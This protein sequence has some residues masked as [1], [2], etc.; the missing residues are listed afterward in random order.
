M[1]TLYTS[2]HISRKLFAH[3]TSQLLERRWLLIDIEPLLSVALYQPCL[4]MAVIETVKEAFGLGHSG[5]I[6]ISIPTCPN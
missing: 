5:A 3:P 2:P 4:T 1:L 6:N